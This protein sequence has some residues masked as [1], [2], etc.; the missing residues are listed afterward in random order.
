M[1]RAIIAALIAAIAIGGAL[2]AFAATRTIETTANVEVR[3]WRRISDGELFLSTRPPQ[4]QWTTHDAPLNLSELSRSG[5]FQL[6]S[7]VT[8]AIPVS[9]EVDVPDAAQ[10]VPTRIAAPTATPSD[11]D[12][13]VAGPCC[14]VRGMEDITGLQ[15]QVRQRMLAVIEFALETYGITHSGD[16]TIN[17]SHSTNGLALRY[18]E[19]FGRQLEEVPDTCSFQEGEHLFIGPQCRSNKVALASEWFA[20]AVGTGD[21]TPTW[22]GHGARDYFANHYATG[23]VPVITEDRFRR[24]LFYERARDIRRDQASDDMKTLVMLYALE[25]YGEF[26]DWLRFYGS[27]AAGLDAGTAFESVFNA[28]L[29]EF[30]DDF[31]EWADHQKI[32][33]FSTAFSSC[34]D[35]SRSLRLQGD[36][37][38]YGSGYPDYRVPLE[39]DHDDDGIVCEGFQAPDE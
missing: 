15:D 26:A 37:S 22:V 35:A 4:G 14:E 13:P 7:I 24:A 9:V 1:N 23:D 39:I 25:D 36:G 19:V 10:A 3:V 28:T 21:V 27:T 31:E 32:I 18:Q 8:A 33:L 34:L 30:Y 17:I 38:G 2:G 6:S 20:R 5:R 11:S 16:I 29:P 12:T